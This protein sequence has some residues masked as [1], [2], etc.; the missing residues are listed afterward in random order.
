MH[1]RSKLSSSVKD[2]ARI[3]ERK[4]LE[5]HAIQISSNGLTLNLVFLLRVIHCNAP[6]RT[7]RSCDGSNDE[8]WTL[9]LQGKVR[10]R[11][12]M[13]KQTQR[14]GVCGKVHTE[15]EEQKRRIRHS[16]GDRRSSETIARAHCETVRI[17]REPHWNRPD[18]GVV[19]ALV[20]LVHWNQR[21]EIKFQ[22]KITKTKQIVNIVK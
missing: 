10:N 6:S 2:T 9:N 21:F 14:S 18:T 22:F 1:L 20:L 5:A 16:E 12:K 13:S 15:V 3:K 17:L 7:I 8:P 4:F 19:S 11:Q